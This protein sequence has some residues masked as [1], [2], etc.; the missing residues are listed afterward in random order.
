MYVQRA[1]RS[2]GS[3]NKLRLLRQEI[4]QIHESIFVTFLFVSQHLFNLRWRQNEIFHSFEICLYVCRY[5]FAI[6]K[7]SFIL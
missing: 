7:K 2:K 4:R 3:Y 5:L 1:L 6:D